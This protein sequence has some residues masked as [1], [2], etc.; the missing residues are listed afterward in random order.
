MPFNAI[1]YTTPAVSSFSRVPVYT[2]TPVSFIEL[3]KNPQNFIFVCKFLD[4][5]EKKI[6]L[7]LRRMQKKKIGSASVII[8]LYSNFSYQILKPVMRPNRNA[9]SA[10]S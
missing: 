4:T 2:F 5:R 9:M 10:F 1:S 3:Q 6:A 8:L 7:F